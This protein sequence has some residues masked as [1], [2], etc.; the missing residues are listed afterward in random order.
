MCLFPIDIAGI[1]RIVGDD[2]VIHFDGSHV[3]GLICG[4]QFQDPIREGADAVSGSMHKTFPGAH[5]AVIMTN[6]RQLAAEYSDATNTF[7]S[8]RHTADMIALA[9]AVREM[10]HEAPRYAADTVRNAQI[11]AQQL[12]DLDIAVMAAKRGY[13][14][15]HQIWLDPEPH[16]TAVDAAQSLFHRGVIVNAIEIPYLES[17]LGLRLGVQEVTYGGLSAEHMPMLATVIAAAITGRQMSKATE[18]RQVLLD[19]LAV[20]RANK[21][22]AAAPLLAHL[23]R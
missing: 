20:H 5:K 4:G 15:S 1:R 2:V 13:T 19:L 21:V 9:F 14:Q 17:R 7:I 18:D 8:H 11:L 23:L 3:M 16:M 22:E 12:A 10:T 6:D